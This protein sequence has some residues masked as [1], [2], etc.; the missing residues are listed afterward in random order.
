MI[1]VVFDSTDGTPV[2]VFEGKRSAHQW[3]RES[4]RPEDLR[5]EVYVP[6][7]RVGRRAVA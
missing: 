1:Y 2:K 3:V 6:R 7:P 5:V 4:A